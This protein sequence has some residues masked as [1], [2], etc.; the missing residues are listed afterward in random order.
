MSVPSWPR[1]PGGKAAEGPDRADDPDPN[2]EP[3]D[4]R[5]D[6]RYPDRPCCLLELVLLVLGAVRPLRVLDPLP[7]RSRQP[8]REKPA[9]H[10]GRLESRCEDGGGDWDAHN[11]RHVYL[12]ELIK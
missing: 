9:E 4:S 10:V 11:I 12:S 7:D 8:Q 2:R 1:S 6:G 5:R 3:V